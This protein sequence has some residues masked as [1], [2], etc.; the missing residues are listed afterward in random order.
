MGQL[1]DISGSPS[2]S[3]SAAAK[4]GN[5]YGYSSSGNKVFNFGANPNTGMAGSNSNNQLLIIGGL[6]L[7]GAYL[8]L[9]KK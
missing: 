5:A 1:S 9:K 3:S 7:A 4:S 6:V 2:T 8:Y